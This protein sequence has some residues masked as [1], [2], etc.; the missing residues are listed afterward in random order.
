MCMVIIMSSKNFVIWLSIMIALLTILFYRE[1]VYAYILTNFVYQNEMALQDAND[2]KV[3]YEYEYVQNVDDY[4]PKNKDELLNVIYTIVNNG[5]DSYT[6]VCDSVYKNCVDDLNQLFDE[7]YHL[8]NINNFVHP[9]NNFDNIY[10]IVDSFGFIQVVVDKLYTKEEIEFMNRE[11]NRIYDS[12]VMPD[13]SL[14]DKVKAIH[15]YIINNTDYLQEDEKDLNGELLFPL[16]TNRAY[17]LLRYGVSN[18][19]G[20]TDTMSIFL[21]KLGLKNYKICSLMGEIDYSKIYHIWN[22]V[23]IDGSWKHLDLTWDDPVSNKN[24]KILTH[25]YFLISS[26]ELKKLDVEDHSFDY[27][28]YSEAK[29]N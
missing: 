18:C 26:S 21:Y 5:W 12:I 14:Y 19:V 15:D 24:K 4:K 8:S 17:G 10:F 1:D 22:L 28:V 20:Y 3:Y 11:V 29:T 23:Y 9:Y 25:D 16:S 27:T 6:F 7:N 13:M 2:Y